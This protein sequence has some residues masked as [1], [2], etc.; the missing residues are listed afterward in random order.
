M[1]SNHGQENFIRR[2]FSSYLF[3]LA[4]MI[5]AI[6]VTFSYVRTYY[7]DYQVRQEIKRLQEDARKLETKKIE[8]LE[9]L[10][11]VQSP[12]FVEEKARTELNMAKVGEKTLIIQS[13]TSSTID[14]RQ[15]NKT[16]VNLGSASNY[17]KWWNLFME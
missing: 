2:F 9:A 7:Q 14:N 12:S 3:L 16:M 4:S 10:R 13:T 1:L 11:Y 17:R 5:I 8:L 15:T 6:M